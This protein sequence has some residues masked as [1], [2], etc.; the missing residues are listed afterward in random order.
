MMVTVNVGVTNEDGT[1]KTEV[2]SYK[3]T[4]TPSD[5]CAVNT[6]WWLSSRYIDDFG[7]RPPPLVR[8]STDSRLPSSTSDEIPLSLT[9]I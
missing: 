5:P 6:D 1:Q 7:V 3:N 2:I 9:R 4:Y 8:F